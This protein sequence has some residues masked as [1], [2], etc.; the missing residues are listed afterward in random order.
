MKIYIS[1]L[2]TTLCFFSSLSAMDEGPQKKTVYDLIPRVV[3]HSTG[4]LEQDFR[5]CLV[6]ILIHN[7]QL[8]KGETV[9]AENIDALLPE[10]HRKVQSIPREKLLQQFNDWLLIRNYYAKNH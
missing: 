10:A 7:A 9:T 2:T 4:N 6:S 1:V 8:K 5:D 3:K